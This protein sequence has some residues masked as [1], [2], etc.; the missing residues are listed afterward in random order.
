M[1]KKTLT[2]KHILGL[3]ARASMQLVD[4]VSRFSSTVIIS[5]GKKSCDA[6]NILDV[7]TLGATRGMPITVKVDG[8]DENEAIVAIEAFFN[9]GEDEPF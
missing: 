7:M 4:C 8:D 9:K 1:I 2:I 6:K 3:H 5:C